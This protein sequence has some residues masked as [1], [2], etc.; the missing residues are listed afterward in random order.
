[1]IRLMIGRDLK[2]LYVPPAAPPGD[3][4]LEIDGVRTADLPGPGRSSLSV[5]RGEILGLAGLVGSGRT[6]L[7]RA[8]FGI[9][10]ADRRRDQARRRAGR[11]S[12]SPRD[13]IERGI[14]LVPEDRKRSGL[15]L[16]MPI[17]R[18]HLARRPAA[19]CARRHRRP[20]R[21]R[22]A[23]AERQRERLDIRTPDGRDRGRHRC[24][25]AT[26]R[27]WCSAKWLS[28]RPRVMIFDEPTRGIDVGAKSEIYRLMR[29]LADQ[30]RRDPDDLQRH[31][32]GDRRQR[33]DRG[34]A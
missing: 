25:A 22:T 33:P 1:M 24:P 7:A 11:R 8:I 18:E 3:A 27:R 12:R 21:R 14:Y 32:G 30:R 26:S 13:A 17:A 16:D 15:L 34:D 2:A 4:V 9:D 5:R 29:E 6:E 23:N 20:R 19:L 31:G 10:R 28:M